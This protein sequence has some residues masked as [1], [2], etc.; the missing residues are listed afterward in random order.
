MGGRLVGGGG[1][2]AGG[3]EVELNRGRRE[4]WVELLVGARG[5]AFVLLGWGSGLRLR[6]ARVG[7]P[8]I[9]QVTT[10]WLVGGRWRRQSRPYF[11]M[12]SV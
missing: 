8:G 6:W 9:E 2:R 1:A 3:V 10:G 5:I 12:H 4:I 7:F 11:W